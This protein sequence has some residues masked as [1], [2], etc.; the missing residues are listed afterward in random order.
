[1]AS[2]F[3]LLVLCASAAASEGIPGAGAL[4][5]A[6][7][8]A[9]DGSHA[10]HDAWEALPLFSDECSEV[11]ANP[12]VKYKLLFDANFRGSGQYSRWALSRDGKATGIG[13]AMRLSTPVH[14]VRAD[15]S[16]EVHYFSASRYTPNVT[17]ST[18]CACEYIVGD[19]AGRPRTLADYSVAVVP[20]SAHRPMSEV[21]APYKQLCPSD[22]A[23]A[24]EL[25]GKPSIEMNS[26]CGLVPAGPVVDWTTLLLLYL[27][28]VLMVAGVL[29]MASTRWIRSWAISEDG[30]DVE[31][32]AYYALGCEQIRAD[33]LKSA[34]SNTSTIIFSDSL[35]AMTRSTSS[36]SILSHDPQSQVQSPPL[37]GAMDPVASVAALNAV[38]KQ[39]GLLV[40]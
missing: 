21:C 28:A 18:N 14:A 20:H 12:F 10:S 19:G 24:R 5:A 3:V 6:S 4:S 34:A 1:M 31:A 26:S 9:E 13:E 38:W 11:W 16:W 25:M 2:T 36:S 15:G 30:M 27:T 32:D 37:F 8:A 22:N 23:T 35:S 33:L 17:N 40:V 39:A 7:S 29:D